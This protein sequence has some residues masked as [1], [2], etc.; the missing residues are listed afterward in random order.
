MPNSA[1]FT[2]AT[3]REVN[4]GLNDGILG[5]YKADGENYY[6]LL[7]QGRGYGGNLE[8]Y[9]SISDN[10]IVDIKV[11]TNSDTPGIKDKAFSQEYLSQYYVD[12]YGAAF[13]F[14]N[15]IDAAAGATY[16]SNGVLQAVRA[17]VN[18]YKMYIENKTKE[19]IMLAK[20]Q[21]IHLSEDGY[22][23]L[24]FD[25]GGIVEGFYKA[26]N[27]DY[28]FII[29]KNTGYYEGLTLYISVSNSNIV[30]IY[31]SENNETDTRD[32]VQQAFS[33]DYLSR[34]YVSVD[35]AVFKRSFEKETDG[36]AKATKTTNAIFDAVK[37]AA[38]QYRKHTEGQND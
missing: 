10:K 26:A 27:E 2:P 5:F 24:P 21:S 29:T 35:N 12:I 25:K 36:I 20:M 38:A 14:G 7:A 18:Q 28:Y 31:V 19:D 3:Y 6:I 15:D 23:P 17:A 37:A 22:N 11:G 32:G 4:T 30:N 16:T 9:V 33:Q 8:L 34:Y 13:E 1:T